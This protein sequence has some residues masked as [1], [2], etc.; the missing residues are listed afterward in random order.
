MA[1]VALSGSLNNKMESERLISKEQFESGSHKRERNE[2]RVSDMSGDENEYEREG[3]R[4]KNEEVN[5]ERN[6]KAES[7]N[8]RKWLLFL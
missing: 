4:K 2:G 6:R 3:K 5:E 8:E 7:V 1:D